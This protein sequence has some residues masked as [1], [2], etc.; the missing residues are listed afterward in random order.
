MEAARDPL[1][2]PLSALRRAH[3]LK[4]IFFLIIF[5]IVRQLAQF[6]SCLP[7]D[8]GSRPG[9]AV[10]SIICTAPRS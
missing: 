10:L 8:D 4:D 1:F 6:F 9:S 3:F 7:C 5:V 2:S